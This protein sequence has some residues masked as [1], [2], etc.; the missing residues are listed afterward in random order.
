MGKK[1]GRIY[2]A[3]TPD[4]AQDPLFVTADIKEMA[5]WAN[6]TESTLRSNIYRNHSGIKGGK[7]FLALTPE[8][9]EEYKKKHETIVKE[10]DPVESPNELVPKE[11]LE[12]YNTLKEEEKVQR[13]YMA[14]TADEYELPLGVFDSV[15]EAAEWGN[16]TITAVYS[17]ISKKITGAYRGYKFIRI[18]FK[19]EDDGEET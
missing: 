18:D 1:K 10:S 19:D 11:N 13:L 16:T 6:I 15:K 3:V 7:K 8:K 9:Y 2:L 12:E 14:V 4:T 17:G 5:R